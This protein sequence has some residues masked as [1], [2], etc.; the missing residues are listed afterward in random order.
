MDGNAQERFDRLCEYVPGVMEKAKA[1]GAAVGILHDGKTYKAGFGVTNVDHPLPVTAETLFQIGSITKTF[2]ATAVMRLVESG[3]VDLDATVRTYVPEFKVLDEDAAARATVRHLLVHNGGWV[4][5]LFT[6]TGPG[7]DALAAYVAKMADL[8]QLA[9][10]GAVMSYN[11]ASFVLAGRVIEAVT[12]QTYENALK[13]L[14]VEPL[15]LETLHL[16]PGEVMTDRFVAGHHVTDDGAQVA[17]PWPL[18][19]CVRPAGGIVCQL[20]DLLRYARF[21]LGDGTSSDDTRILETA[22]LAA[23][24]SP[25][26]SIWGDGEAIGLAWFLRDVDGRRTISHGGG[27]V[28]QITHLTLVPER[29]FAVAVLTNADRGGSVTKDVSRWALR[30]YL[31]LESG[32]PEALESTEGELAAYTGF[33]SRPF[34]E[35][36]LGMLAGQLVGQAV[37]KG[38]FPTEDVPTPPPPPPVAIALCEPDRLLVTAG[39]MKGATGEV[40]RRQDGTIGWLR[41]SGRIHR[42]IDREKARA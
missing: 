42:R 11:N 22:S 33:Y 17:R 29:A 23:M 9:P 2:T 8:E 19:R 12:G 25:Q 39:P 24:Q 1:P 10:L 6:D 18:P 37:Y 31:G 4:G 16:D 27:T 35:I 3:K 26:Q 13:E 40:L 7:N 14:V 38:S 30:E 5:D 34:M 28:G 15:G 21:H 36:E 20:E 32:D 41:M